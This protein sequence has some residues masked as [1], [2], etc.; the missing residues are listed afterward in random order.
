MS[1]SMSSLEVFKCIFAQY[2]Q[3][4]LGNTE[5]KLKIFCLSIYKLPPE[6]G[7]HRDS[8]MYLQTR[9]KCIDDKYEL[10]CLNGS[11]FVP[12]FCWTR[13]LTFRKHRNRRKTNQFKDSEIIKHIFEIFEMIKYIFEIFEIIKQIFATHSLAASWGFE[14]SDWSRG[15]LAS[16]WWAWAWG[17]P[18]FSSPDRNVRIFGFPFLARQPTSSE[19]A[20]K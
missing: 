17:K 14:A 16:D 9:T 2:C 7:K 8:K 1:S 20:H 6:T 10:N 11:I 12:C 19:R 15:G 5:M 4:G 3:V 13:T 18:Y